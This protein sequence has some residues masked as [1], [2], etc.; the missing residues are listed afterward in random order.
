MSSLAWSGRPC[1]VMIIHLWSAGQAGLD[2]CVVTQLCFGIRISGERPSGPHQSPVST[3]IEPGQAETPQKT[4]T[5]VSQ[6]AVC[7]IIPH[8]PLGLLHLVKS[9]HSGILSHFK[10]VQSQDANFGHR[11]SGWWWLLPPCYSLSF[12]QLPSVRKC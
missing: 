2:T 6:N 12:P 4:S 9:K 3:N 1:D 7:C 8:K 5:I 11:A 10:P